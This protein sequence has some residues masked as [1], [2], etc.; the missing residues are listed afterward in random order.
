MHTYDDAQCCQGQG[1]ADP[2][3]E[4]CEEVG[5]EASVVLALEVSVLN[6]DT[7]QQIRPDRAKPLARF[8]SVRMNE[9]GEPQLECGTHRLAV[10]NLLQT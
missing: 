5:G 10:A 3:E 1:V 8:S 9:A 6:L 4:L 2:E 7:L